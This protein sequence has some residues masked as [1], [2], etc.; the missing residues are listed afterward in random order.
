VS[1]Q[2]SGADG[3]CPTG[4]AHLPARRAPPVSQ[5]SATARGAIVIISPV[6]CTGGKSHRIP[7]LRA[8]VQ[9]RGRK[10]RCSW[11]ARS[12]LVPVPAFAGQASRPVRRGGWIRTGVRFAGCGTLLLYRD[13]KPWDRT[14]G[15]MALTWVELWGFE[16]Q[17]SCMPW[18]AGP[19]TTARDRSPATGL[20]WPFVQ[21]RSA[22][23]TRVHCGR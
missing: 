9:R 8:S 22:A 3:A 5:R 1:R 15:F 10:E 19:F 7:A 14:F 17:T 21:K 2:R 18:N 13:P 16:P 23:F 12:R 20:S 4:S 6:R 11:S